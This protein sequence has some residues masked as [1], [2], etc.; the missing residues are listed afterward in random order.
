[1]NF[2]RTLFAGTL[3]LLI[4]TS[5]A[6]AQVKKKP[7]PSPK[8]KPAS[9]AQQIK[10]ATI[11]A[12]A[13][14]VIG[15]L[16]NGL[17]Y[18]IRSNSTPKNRAMLFLVNK[19]GS[20]IETDAQ[21]G[22]AQFIEHMA[23][24]GTRDY[25]KADLTNYLQ[26]PG[27]KFDPD[28]HANTSF[29][30]TI[31]Q[32][33][34]PTD[35][36]TIFDK[37]FNVLANFAGYMKLDAAEIEKEKA[38]AADEAHQQG[39]G[40]QDRIQQQTLPV[41]LNNSKYAQRLIWGKEDA[42]KAFNE[43][44]VKGFYHDWYRPDMQAVIV[45]GDF[46]AKHVEQ[47]IKEKFSAL[48]NPT[49][50][51]PRPQF[52]V[53]PSPG[54]AVKFVTDKSVNY[55]AAQII[56]RHPQIIIKAP[57][58]FAQDMRINV[59]NQML[60]ARLV[61]IGQ[62][63][64]PPYGYAQANYGSFSGKQDAFSAL[65]RT[66]PGG[67]QA[68]ITAM[69]AELER[70]KKFGFTL[71]ELERAKQNAL[72]QMNNIYDA[73]AKSNSTNFVGQYI[74]NFIT[75]E[76]I[77]SI[78]YQYNFYVNNIGKIDLKEINALANRFILDQNRAIIVVFPEAEKD[79][80]PNEKNLLGW[81]ADADKNLT[82]YND[83]VNTDP[84]MAT[85]PKPGKV[86][87]KEEDSV[88]NVTRLTLSNGVKVILKPTKFKE[89][90]ILI[91]AYSFGGTSLANDQDFLS[92]NMAASVVANSGVA[93]LTQDQLNQKLRGAQ[94]N[95]SPYITE[96]V[97]GISGSAAPADFETAMQ[98]L[99]LYFT[100]PRIDA[101]TWQEVINQSKALLTKRSADPASVYQDT[102][103][104]LLNNHNMRAMVGTMD[105]LNKASLDKAFDFYKARFADA[106]GFTFTLVG[107]FTV[108][109]VIPYLEAYLGS[110][111]ANN[112][113]EIYRSLNVHPVTGQVI[114]TITKGSGDKS[115]VQ[116]VYSG[117]YD[118]NEANNIQL[119]AL[120]EILNLKLTARF[121]EK[122]SGAFS[123]SAGINNVK[124][125]ESRYKVTISFLCAPADVDKLTNGIKDEISKLKQ[126]GADQ[127]N[128]DRFIA[129][130]SRSI[131]TQLRQN[132]FW[133]GYLAASAQDNE[134]P[135]RIIPHIQKLNE[136]TVQS[137][138]DAANKFLSGTNLIEL[139][140]LPEKK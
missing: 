12:D 81:L 101:E 99:N 83:D 93:K 134:D 38:I 15:K 107:N 67:L 91:G 58:D 137:T 138:K 120:E 123:L 78:E 86:V 55:E 132:Y 61:E 71:T 85:L 76:A 59:F 39:K 118:Y 4:T 16:P 94:I 5:A 30:E 96:N 117:T 63:R 46:D 122:E 27:T 140:L 3:A 56:T 73:R 128:I 112:H 43:A 48:K 113:K 135:D 41:I 37:G 22:M 6:F 103:T 126:T 25:T 98:L 11:P 57:A 82:A 121:P 97:Q 52:A 119:D 49:P 110:L 13:N 100:Q 44:S 114:R 68:G 9:A 108:D 29:D 53:T 45:V 136:V 89:D 124:T 42:I 139:I 74:Q 47:L 105:Q 23:F 80:L 7:T 2:N 125:P 77:T 129:E 127:K 35:T 33:T 34:V 40:A 133:A 62:L 14:V 28:A 115:T 84:L 1:M 50:E 109:Q 65:V 64:N 36:A 10:P 92:A 26:K 130:E 19:A 90:Q 20:V 106:S 111:P 21:Q 75:G 32:I 69:Y 24:T 116:L 102:V 31:Y 88:I 51:K 18:Y 60:N 95:I 17:T 72:T 66:R 131:Q 104:A 79:K 54:T 87:K 70:A 8:G